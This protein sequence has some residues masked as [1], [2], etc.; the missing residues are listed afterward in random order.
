[1][2]Y[3]SHLLLKPFQ[4]VGL[5]MVSIAQMRTVNHEQ[6]RNL[7]KDG[8]DV[9]RSKQVQLG[10]YLKKEDVIRSKKLDI[11]V[12]TDNTQGSQKEGIL[13]MGME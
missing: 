13:G 1:M 4:E 5:T 3:L 11:N 9:S 7:V 6:I 12:I 10:Q 8:K 2:I